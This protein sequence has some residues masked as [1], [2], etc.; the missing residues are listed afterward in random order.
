MSETAKPNHQKALSIPTGRLNRMA[1]LGGL[2]TA[3]AGN[4]AT[5]G[6]LELLQGRK[7][8]LADLL[9]TPSNAARVADQLAR[10]RGAA[11]KAGQLLSMETSDLLPPELAEILGRLRSDAHFMPPAQLKK[12]LMANW[13]RDFLRHFKQ[14]DVHPIAAAS[15]G[16]V[17]RAHSKDGRDL[18]IKVQ[19]P[20]IR[21]SIDSD[22]RNLGLILRASGIMPET[23]DISRL[24]EE[25]AEQLHEETDYD[26]E[27]AALERFGAHLGDDPDFVLPKRHCD[28]STKDILVMDYLDGVSIETVAD[29]DQAT[30]DRVASLIIALTLR[31][32]FELHD[33]QTDPNFANYRFIPDTGQIILLDFGATRSFA[34]DLVASYRSLFRAAV[35]GNNAQAF[36]DMIAIGLVG[37][38]MPDKDRDHILR[39]FD[40]AAEPLRTGGVLDFGTVGLL[41]RLRRAGMVLADEQVALHAPPTDTLLLQ[42]KILGCYLLAERLRARVNLDPL[43]ARFF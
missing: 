20:G 33:M 8:K 4:V 26:R 18:A 39:L 27:G 36:Q 6:G 17:H 14:F 15:I 23:F 24:L 12:V 40:M 28:L 35:N 25:G 3:L 32:L 19:Y 11:M 37:A 30:R 38:D 43:L 42:R 1:R 13:G 9:M 5:R 34:P 41:A 2:T 10:M 16:Q 22:M 7:P 21:N 29:M 31:E